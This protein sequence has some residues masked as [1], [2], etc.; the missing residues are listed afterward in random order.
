MAKSLKISL[1][2]WNDFLFLLRGNYNVYAPVGDEKNIEYDLISED[3]LSSIVYNRPFPASPLKVFFLPI[4]ENVS[5]DIIPEKN[6]LIIG[7]PS[8]DLEALSILD[9]MYLSEPFIDSYY[10]RRRRNSIIVGTDCYSIKDNCHCTSYDGNPFPVRY[11]DIQLSLIQ[12]TV[13]LTIR[14]DKGEELIKHLPEENYEVVSKEEKELIQSKR[15]EVTKLLHH[16]NRNLP[17][18]R[19]TGCMV[20]ESADEI[21]KK[22]SKTCVSC[23]ACATI[24]PTCTCFLLTDR[25]GFEKVRQMDA[26]QYPGFARTAS[27]EDPLG[28]R[29][30]RF[31]NRYLC[32]YVWKPAKFKSIACTGCGRCI[33]TCI[34]NINKNKLFVELKGK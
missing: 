3:N 31:R 7:V 34:G 33:V 27:G 13:F 16:R 28:D 8:C 26:C 22:Y 5:K 29:F 21:W 30:V 15:R 6:N 11:Y 12:Q 10:A 1:E 19:E 18:Y 2:K 17:D 4:K 23:G 20:A 32:K 25:P 9:E 14:S 24:C